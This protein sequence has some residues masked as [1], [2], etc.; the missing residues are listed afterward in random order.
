VESA[1]GV[2]SDVRIAEFVAAAKQKVG[3]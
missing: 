1:P 2:K 3:A